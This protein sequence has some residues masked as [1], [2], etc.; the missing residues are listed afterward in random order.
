MERQTRGTLCRLR[1]NNG[2]EYQNKLFADYCKISRVKMKFTAPYS[3]Q[4]NG[5][6]ERFNRTILN[7]A[8]TMLISARL[9][10]QYW[11]EAVMTAVFIKNRLACKSLEWKSPYQVLHERKPNVQN[12]RTFESAAY[13][14]VP[15]QLRRKFDEKSRK[16]VLL[17]NNETSK[18]YR[19]LDWANR[20]VIKSTNSQFL[21]SE[22][23]HDVAYDDEEL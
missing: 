4:Q 11:G 9:E 1:S 12:L 20:S 7:I 14:K 17:G 6:A 15:D 5:L 8:R 16:S 18:N 2:G 23:V 13:F 22:L 19:L 3:S 10:K 21:E